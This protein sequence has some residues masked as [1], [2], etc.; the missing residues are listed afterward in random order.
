MLKSVRVSKFIYMFLDKD[1]KGYL[2][3][4]WVALPVLFAFVLSLASC[5]GDDYVDTIPENSIAV[6][7]IDMKK[8][9]GQTG[10]DENKAATL[11]NE[12]LKVDDA[13]ECGIDFTSKIYVFESAEGNIGLVA[14]V[15]D[16]GKLDKWFN[17]L[18][19]NGYCQQTLER[20]D[21]RFTVIKD[22]WVA[23]F[24]SDA[25]LVMGPVMVAQ[26]AEAK[27][28]IAKYL[29][30]EEEQ[31]IKG[32]PMFDKLDSLSSPIAVVAQ[33]AAL[34]S[35]FVAPFTLGAP[36]EADPS[37]I[38]IAA[39]MNADNGS[40]VIKGETF[41]LNKSI[42]NALKESV[43][44]FRPI[45][46]KYLKTMPDNAA[47]GMFMNVDGKDFI[48]LLHSNKSLQALLTGLNTAIDMDNII[49]SIDGDLS[50]VMHQFGDDNA[51]MQMSAQLG[52]KSFLDD[53]DYWKQSCPSG[54]K[55]T[56]WAKD[57]YCFTNGSMSYYFGVT[58]DLQYYSGSTEELALLSAGKLDGNSDAQ[59]N[60]YKPL[61]TGVEDK[62]KGQRMCMVLNIGSILDK[63]GSD[64]AVSGLLKPLLGNINTV[65]Y[66][67]K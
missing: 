59:A 24:S 12:L 7:S 2:G 4:F 62:I 14:K 49:K 10:V 29:K 53:V 60:A 44:V 65:I 58:S 41:S 67:I 33:A 5:S 3:K 57:A 46:D 25:L 40:L 37:Q 66:T 18:S 22:S 39:E 27:Q 11:V 64:S 34:P 42:D 45:T 13:S 51:A 35:K 32:T 36:K 55:I 54:S 15:S 28:Q 52:S 8:T 50:V 43:K 23:G 47:F 26:Q 20:S 31:S 21:S 6:V 17:E 56:D 30:Q 1:M 19:K 61:L 9:M 48:G 16:D 38:I 63:E